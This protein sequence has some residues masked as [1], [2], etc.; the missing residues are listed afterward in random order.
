M[1]SPQIKVL[2]VDDSE[3][4]IRLLTTAFS[5]HSITCAG[6]GKE[7]LRLLLKDDF[8]VILLDVRMPDMDGFHTAELIRLSERAK[9]IPLIFLTGYEVDYAQMRR[10]FQLGAVDFIQKPFDIEALKAKIEVFAQIYRKQLEMQKQAQQMSETN[11]SL[12]DTNRRLLKQHRELEEKIAKLE[13]ESCGQFQ[14][15]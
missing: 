7:A 5:S 2:V 14:N 4:I 8:A 3:A 12:T 15:L 6:S 10:A 9:D 13:Q 11:S 1:T